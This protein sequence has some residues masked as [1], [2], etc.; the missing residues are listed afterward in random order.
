MPGRKADPM[1]AYRMQV[2][3]TNHYL[4]AATV[5]TEYRN[6]KRI[7]RYTHWGTLSRE[8]V[9]MPNLK[10]VK[11]PQDIRESF[12]YPPEWDITEVKKLDETGSTLQESDAT[13]V[14]NTI[15]LAEDANNRTGHG[16]DGQV[17]VL[18]YGSVWFLERVAENRHLT[19]D[20]LF[21]FGQDRSRA[22]NVLSIAM[23]SCLTGRNHDGLMHAQRVTKYPADHILSE[24]SIEQ[25]LYGIT[26]RNR[27]DFCKARIGRLSDQMIAFNSTIHSSWGQEVAERLY[28]AH[29]NIRDVEYSNQLVGYAM[30][31][32]EPAYHRS[33]PGDWSNGQVIRL[34]GTEMKRLGA[35][36]PVYVMNAG[37]EKKSVADDFSDIGVATFSLCDPGDKGVAKCLSK[38]RFDEFGLPVNMKY[39]DKR[40]LFHETF[41]TVRKRAPEDGADSGCVCY[42][43]FLNPVNRPME[44]IALSEAIKAEREALEDKK[45]KGRLDDATMASLEKS[46]KYHNLVVEDGDIG[47][48]KSVFIKENGRA[49]RNA[50][51][52]C[53]FFAYKVQNAELDGSQILDACELRA[54][55]EKF[56]EAKKDQLDYH[57]SDDGMEEGKAGREFVVFLAMILESM[58]QSLWENSKELKS[59]YKTPRGILDEMA[60]VKVICTKGGKE[61]L[62][63]F[64]PEQVR[65]CE[66]AGVMV[67][68]NRS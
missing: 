28:G 65:I 33:F 37:T 11:T 8:L 38:I 59:A 64:R 22:F 6:G 40:K 52:E 13:D 7:R 16:K 50:L 51:S 10:F 63:E 2:H 43:L 34:A 36:S 57:V 14:K 58:I 20:L 5:T 12:I 39:D 3:E 23:H 61:C 4:Y 21:A 31:T 45:D 54:R 56:F 53:G 9:F 47:R 60:D 26:D 27:M 1:A 62:S 15:M 32:R 24:A 17:G 19:E 25:L 30:E 66:L 46:L 18:L 41:R 29:R 68:E 55:Q 44:L 35:R 49:I 48:P 67:P 42:A